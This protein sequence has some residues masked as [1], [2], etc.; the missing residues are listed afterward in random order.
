MRSPE[1]ILQ[2]C[3]AT[4]GL[5]TKRHNDVMYML[6]RKSRSI[7][8]VTK[9]ET[10]LHLNISFV[11]PDIVAW[12]ADDPDGDILVLDP[13]IVSDDGRISLETMA[14]GKVKKYRVPAVFEECQALV[15]RHKEQTNRRSGEVKDGPNPEKFKRRVVLIVVVID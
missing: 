12:I 9:L 8:F 14:E 3:A 1:H 10:R 15:S 7:G 13:T 4:H 5:R 11:E 6:A 2:V